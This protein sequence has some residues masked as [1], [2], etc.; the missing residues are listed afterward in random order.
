MK[1][2][3]PTACLTHGLMRTA[4]LLSRGFEAAAAATGVSAAQFT[5]LALLSGHGTLTVGQI[6]AAVAADRTTMT[7][8][9]ALLA[10]NGWIAPADAE[11]RRERAWELTPAGRHKLA[12]VMPH[13]Q[14]WQGLLVAQLGEA[15]ATDL[16]TTLRRLSP[17]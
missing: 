4:R 9:L 1:L 17:P 6:A 16:L 2:T 13:W 14:A 10:R 11:D 3:H 5:T 12:E 7:R 8:N 15:G